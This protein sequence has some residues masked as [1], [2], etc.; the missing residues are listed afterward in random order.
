MLDHQVMDWNAGDIAGFMRGYAK[1]DTT[2]FASG[3]EITRG[4]QTVFARYLKRYGD[5]AAMGRLTFTELEITVLAP[6][7]AE[8]FGH[9]RLDRE[10]DTPHGL[11][12]LLMRKTPD[13]WRGVH[14]HTSS[15]T[16]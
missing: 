14:D 12:T 3:G 16:P 2:R 1:S 11:F 6:D 4:W 13:G 15:A 10:E 8:V 7:R 9:W 5:R